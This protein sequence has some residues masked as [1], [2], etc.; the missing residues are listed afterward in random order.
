MFK[1][2]SIFACVILIII[3][4]FA[5][6]GNSL[7]GK[8][9]WD[10]DHL[11]RDNLYIKSWAHI[12]KI[13][14]KDI[15]A[16][17]AVQYNSY[18]PLQMFT[19]LIDYS[20]WKLDVRGY[21]LSN[22]LFHIFATLA[23]FWFVTILFDS[24]PLALFT[25]L[26]FLIHPVHTEAVAYISGRSDPL[27]LLFMLLCL[28]FYIK[29][30]RERR[31][32]FYLVAL[33]SYVLALLSRE[34]S[35]VLPAL[36]L[37]YHYSFKKKIRI[38][39][40][41]PILS[42]GLIYIGLRVTVF[43]SIMPDISI[44]NSVFERIP[45]FFVAI[46]NYIRLLFLPLNLHMEYGHRSFSF[47]DPGAVLGVIILLLLVSYAFKKRNTDQLVS[48]SI[49][50]F[51]I[52]LLPVSNLYP[53]NAYM[54][55]HWLYLPSIGFFLLLARGLSYA[56][57][58]KVLRGLSIIFTIV[59]LV[60]YSYLTFRQNIHWREPLV[61]Y[62]RTMKYAPDSP[63][64]YNNLGNV[65]FALGRK[66]E[67]IGFYRKAIEIK[68]DNAGAYN[69][70]GVLYKDIN[71]PQEAIDLY[72]KALEIKPGFG[73]AYYNLGNAYYAINEYEKAVDSYK[74]AIAI[75]PDFVDAY[76][77]L[78]VV[79]RDINMEK[80]A[81]SAYNKAI[82]IN[83]SYVVAY[84]NLGNL[85]MAANKH[86]EAIAAYDKAIQ[87]AIEIEPDLAKTYSN[88]GLAYEAL[89]KNKEAIASYQKSIELD[90]DNAG[91]FYN[92]GNAYN[93]INNKQEA[94][95]SYQKAISADSQYAQAYNN[96]GVTYV[97][98]GKHS[99]AVAL[100]DKAIEINP[101]YVKAYFNKA[102]A[103]EKA[104]RLKEGIE[105]YRK[106]IQL[107]GTEYEPYIGYAKARIS[108]LEGRSG[109]AP[110]PNFDESGLVD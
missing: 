27:A 47:T 105:T 31:A 86:Q 26:F 50:W 10:D 62:Q 81:A 22:T 8:F 9:V 74:R 64:L 73:Q 36:L 88:L 17:T 98:I 91:S 34:N 58:R 18:R 104:G 28:I 56:Y 39:Q 75:H 21:H 53:L 42:A 96:L 66:E 57:R 14:T 30:L 83:P 89:N 7:N 103:C 82:E 3:L 45:G 19:C 4:G 55:E 24:L 20:L 84:N 106:F 23:L 16:A 44:C 85:Y 94:I 51:F 1:R 63:K 78:G 5:V 87:R 37:L 33:L 54:A 65:C 68:P 107:A 79:Y 95:A 108:L 52:T 29:G 38:W 69:N 77:N 40:F 15:G 72:R 90:P 46:T 49:L 32:G 60:L 102:L 41:L 70:L 35:L 48:F 100:L 109:E 110:E 101:D 67:A 25:S 2:E 59:L 99:E 92:L 13:F 61:F 97:N 71:R 43:K 80:E 11:I 12:N 93:A 6:Y 76:N